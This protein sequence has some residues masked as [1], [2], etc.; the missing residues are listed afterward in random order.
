M[1]KLQAGTLALSTKEGID[2]VRPL[3]AE[4]A[5]ILVRK[6]EAILDK[7]YQAYCQYISERHP[8]ERK[9]DI[10]YLKHVCIPVRNRF[11]VLLNRLITCLTSENGDYDISDSEHDVEYAAR[12]VV[13]AR[14][15]D[16]GSHDIIKMVR[17]FAQITEQYVLAE[18]K[19]LEYAFSSEVLSNLMNEL[20]YITFEDLWVSS[21]VGFRHHHGLIQGLLSKTMK[22]QEEERQRLAQE[23]HD[24][25]LQM[26]AVIPLRLEMA[27]Q[28]LDSDA[29]A[30]KEELKR[31]SDL[32]KE[33]TREGRNLLYNL[34]SS[35]VERKGLIFSLRTF[36]KRIEKDFDIP[37]M[38]EVGEEVEQ[39]LDGFQAV[40]LFRIIQEAL[41]N[42]GKHSMAKYAKV[43]IDIEGEELTAVIED[44]GIGFDSQKESKEGSEFGH[45]GIICMRERAKLLGGHLWIDS[46][47]GVGTHVEIEIPL[48]VEATGRALKS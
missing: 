23:I 5:E 17:S 30:A 26:L 37:V 38:L 43:K 2:D 19:A 8:D 7:F 25:F 11:S 36:V 4:V 22:T 28:L 40:T 32:V 31:L 1:Q 16:L 24:E 3:K 12:F 42:V 45:F 39:R 15:K 34:H 6:R 20:I 27:E 44:H 35:W 10:E 41:Y 9:K 18:M 47:E 13:P 33:N 14:Y 46:Q 29:S 48:D 21:V